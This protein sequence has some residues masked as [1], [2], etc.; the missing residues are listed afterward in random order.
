MVNSAFI[1]VFVNS[2]MIDRLFFISSN[3]YPSVTFDTDLYCLL[4][5]KFIYVQSEYRQY[6]KRYRDVK[7][8]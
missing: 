4:Q 8:Y 5:N 1:R 2:F 7:S 6:A 3:R